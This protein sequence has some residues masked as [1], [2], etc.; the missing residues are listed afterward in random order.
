[1]FSKKDPEYWVEPYTGLCVPCGT[2]I[3]C[4]EEQARQVAVRIAHHS[5][6][7]DESC[8]V[9]LTYS[10]QHL[11][12][13]GSLHYPDLQKF[14]KRLRIN[15]DRRYGIKRIQYYAVGEYGDKSK[16]AHYHACI[17]GHAFLHNRV[18]TQTVP[19]LVWTNPFI[20][21]T[22]GLGGVRIGALTFQTANYTAS[23]LAKKLRR[24]QQYVRVDEDSGE[25]IKLVQPRAFSSTKP[26]L[27]KEWL[28]QWGERVYEHDRVVINGR[29]QKPPKYYDKWMKERSPTRMEE[30]KKERIAKA[31]PSTPEDNRARAI[32]AHARGQRMNKTV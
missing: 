25:L 30:I 31:E 8:F 24:K 18:I 32:N 3:L 20:E 21:E 12:A 4:R 23:Y 1:M 22:W 19:Y 11:P 26:A 6:G 17:F 28:E 5:Q 7:F 9:T 15:L 2:C 10:D 14:W 27:A 13:H 16:R 29:P